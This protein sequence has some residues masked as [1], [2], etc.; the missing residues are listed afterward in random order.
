[1]IDPA[2]AVAKQVKRLLE[3]AGMKIQLQ[4]QASVRFFT[5]G[6]PSAM[7]SMLPILVGDSGKVESVT[8]KSDHDCA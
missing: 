1:V 2:P 8:W 3:V 5:S 6:D 4:G 7:K